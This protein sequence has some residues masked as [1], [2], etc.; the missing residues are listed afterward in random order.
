MEFLAAACACLCRICGLVFAKSTP[1]G[2]AGY[3]IVAVIDPSDALS[4]SAM[5]LNDKGEVAG[6]YKTSAD[7]NVPLVSFVWINNEFRTISVQGAI[8]TTAESVNERGFVTGG[9]LA[10]AADACNTG[11]RHGFIMSPRET[12]SRCRGTRYTAW[13]TTSLA[14]AG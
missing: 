13:S 7:C 11:Y 5:H 4:P 6:R 14:A 1:V 2:L 10:S 3:E 8:S 12:S 9:L